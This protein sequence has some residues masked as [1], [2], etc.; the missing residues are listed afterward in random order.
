MDKLQFSNFVD[1]DLDL[2]KSLVRKNLGE[3]MASGDVDA[4]RFG[5]RV[6]RNG[7]P[8]DLTGVTVYGYAILPNEETHKIKGSASGN[9]AFVD[10]KQECYLYDGAITVTIKILGDGFETALAIFDAINTRT[11]TGTIVSENRVIYDVDTILTIIDRMEQA[12]KDA[13][14]AAEAANVAAASVD[15]KVSEAN[16]ELTKKVTANTTILTNLNR[17]VLTQS[18]RID[19]VVEDVSRLSE[20]KADSIIVDAS[21]SLVAITDAAAQPA[22]SLVSTIEPKQAGSGEPSPDNV[23]PISGWNAVNVRRGADNILPPLTD[24]Y[25]DSG[26]TFTPQVDGSV[27]LNGTKNNGRTVV[28]LKMPV[29]VVKGLTHYISIGEY[30]GTPITDYELQGFNRDK[31]VNY[32]SNYNSAGIN[33]FIPDGVVLNN[34]RIYPQ[35]SFT[36][37]A[38]YQPYQDQSLTAELPETIYGGELD[39]ATGELTVTH[40][41]NIIDGSSA[42]NLNGATDDKSLFMYYPSPAKKAGITNFKADIFRIGNQEVYTMSGRETSGGIEFALPVTVEQNVTAAKAWFAE[43][44]TQLVYELETPYTIQLTPQQLN[45]LKGT[46]NVWSDC[47]DTELVYV[48]DTKLYIDQKFEQLQNAILAQG[49]NV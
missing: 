30:V 6:K 38:P 2:N 3:V 5:V 47:G 29:Y 14:A 40:A 32:S 41:I 17:T 37:D 12:E 27:M 49:A 35:V 43:N 46:N 36:K 20:M 25:T 13:E 21:G 18:G 44:P 11:E 23:R 39:W 45:M 33:L 19:D 42:F 48:A 10:I 7:V 24:S 31:V 15:A 9:E 26:I 8:V 34:V 22:I 1:V 4:N 16:A 28:L